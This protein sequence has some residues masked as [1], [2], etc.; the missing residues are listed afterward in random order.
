MHIFFYLRKNAKIEREATRNPSPEERRDGK[1]NQTG[2]EIRNG[3]QEG[4]NYEDE[5]DRSTEGSTSNRRARIREI[6][7]S[8][9]VTDADFDG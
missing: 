1:Y 8:N 2:R 4:E 5:Y 6:I 7:D 9:T 3:I